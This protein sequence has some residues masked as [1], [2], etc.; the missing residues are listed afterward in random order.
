M[1]PT[2]FVDYS[3]PDF[4]AHVAGNSITYSTQYQSFCRCPEC[5]RR[6]ITVETQHRVDTKPFWCEAP[7]CDYWETRSVRKEY[8][9]G[10]DYAFPVGTKTARAFLTGWVIKKKKQEVPKGAAKRIEI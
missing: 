6:L 10:L 1:N 2:P 9:A 3:I 4:G 5:G 8:E 7:G